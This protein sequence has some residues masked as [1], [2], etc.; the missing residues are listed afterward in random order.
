MTLPWQPVQLSACAALLECLGNIRA[1][2]TTGIQYK[3]KFKYDTIAFT[4]MVSSKGECPP[5][6]PRQINLPSIP[7]IVAFYHT[8]LEF[9]VKDTWLDAIKVGQL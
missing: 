3:I 6:D 1:T 2:D 7:T 9:P 5:F 8:C 4:V